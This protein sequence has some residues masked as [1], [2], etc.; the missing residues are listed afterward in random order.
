MA[1]RRKSRSGGKTRT[2][3]RTVKSYVTRAKQKT[4]GIVAGLV[5]GAGGSLVNRYFP[6]LGQWTQPAADI[7]TGTMMNNDTLST[8][9]GRSIG[10][11]LAAGIGNGSAAPAGNSNPLVG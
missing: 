4:G 8:I 3:T 7:V 6:A 5:A 1:R 11:M 2:V 10:A 9:G